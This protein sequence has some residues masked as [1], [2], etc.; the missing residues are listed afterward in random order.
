MKEESQMA[1]CNFF[2]GET[3]I[4]RDIYKYARLV[5]I[6]SQLRV[7]P[8]SQTRG[9]R[10]RLISIGR[11]SSEYIGVELIAAQSKGAAE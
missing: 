6:L 10:M 9:K 7:S 2:L 5:A 3:Y 11:G 8:S 4:G 1:I